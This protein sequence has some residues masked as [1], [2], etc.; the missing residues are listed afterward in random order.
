[1]RLTI[2]TD[3]G[4]VLTAPIIQGSQKDLLNLPTPQKPIAIDWAERPG[5][6]VMDSLPLTPERE[7]SF[8]V[9]IFLPNG[10]KLPRLYT[11]CTL[12]T[13]GKLTYS[14]RIERYSVEEYPDGDIYTLRGTITEQPIQQPPQGA[15][16]D[17]TTDYTAAQYTLA[18]G[19]TLANIGAYP[20]E[21]WYTQLLNTIK[22]KR[23]HR[24]NPARRDARDVTLPTLLQASS[25]ERLMNA[26]ERLISALYKRTRNSL[27]TPWRR[28]F[29]YTF[30]RAKV[31]R[32]DFFPTHFFII[33]DLT[34]TL[35]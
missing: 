14:A 3:R 19:I 10:E 4:D 16:I 23:Q 5:L 30:T 26:R 34:L 24:I 12:S 2:T 13:E 18:E 31:S 7:R 29:D 15:P 32:Y 8:S 27:A 28:P 6:D 1:M 25:F 22:I 35:L 33:Y 20:L 17:A 11:N 9:G 21:G